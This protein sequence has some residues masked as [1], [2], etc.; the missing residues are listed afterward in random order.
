MDFTK[1]KREPF[2]YNLDQHKRQK[3]KFQIYV[4]A[5]VNVQENNLLQQFWHF[6]VINFLYELNPRHETVVDE[7]FSGSL[8]TLV[9]HIILHRMS[10]T[11]FESRLRS[12]QRS[13][14]RLLLPTDYEGR[15]TLVSVLDSIRQPYFSRI[16]DFAYA[17]SCRSVSEFDIFP[18][19]ITLVSDWSSKLVSV[20]FHSK[21]IAVLF[22][23]INEAFNSLDLSWKSNCLDVLPIS[24]YDV[25]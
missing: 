15:A 19:S 9:P 14:L 10:P 7:P 5:V 18:E 2:G 21:A 4:R 6:F 25:C 3:F 13:R 22:L 23:W 17:R 16:R 24:Y 11:V 12:F 8:T 20:S 1:A